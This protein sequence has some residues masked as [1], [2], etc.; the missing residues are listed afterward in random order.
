M[1][2]TKISA[3]DPVKRVDFYNGNMLIGSTETAPFNLAVKGVAAGNYTIVAKAVNLNGDLLVSN[4]IEVN[5]PAVSENKAEKNELFSI[6]LG[7][8]PATNILN[9]YVARS[10][11]ADKFSINIYSLNGS[12]VKTIP[13]KNSNQ[14]IPVDISPYTNCMY[15]VKM[16]C[17]KEMQV[18]KFVKE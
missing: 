9:I 2:N 16:I 11:S 15:L 12:I 10:G 4:V 13:V 1:L 8:N 7:P 6:K 3:T 14:V 5:V 18:L 17:G